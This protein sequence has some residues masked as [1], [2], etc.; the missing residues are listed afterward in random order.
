[1]ESARPSDQ[2]FEPRLLQVP[3]SFSPEGLTT[4]GS[5]EEIQSLPVDGVPEGADFS[6]L[7]TGETAIAGAEAPE[8]QTNAVP[9]IGP[10]KLT[11]LRETL[12]GITP[13]DDP[14]NF[15]VKYLESGK[16]GI[17]ELNGARVEQIP[18]VDGVPDAFILRDTDGKPTN[19]VQVD[20][21][22]GK[23]KELDQDEIRQLSRRLGGEDL[24]REMPTETQG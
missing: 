7:W 23:F 4:D 5:M 9:D 17:G 2:P 24:S 15:N 10:G 1:M 20:E 14:G 3:S 22:T 11:A 18:H 16:L 19:V 6:E 12:E 21:V 13:E 8:S